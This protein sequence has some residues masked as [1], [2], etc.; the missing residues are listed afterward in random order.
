MP[1]G[2]A[3]LLLLGADLYGGYLS[4]REL[5]LERVDGDLNV[6]H[7]TLTRAV[8]E[9]FTEA[10]RLVRAVRKLDKD[11]EAT[12]TVRERCDALRPQLALFAPEARLRCLAA[13]PPKRSFPVS[14]A[15]EQAYG[16]GE[17][18]RAVIDNGH[19][20]S[21]AAGLIEWDAPDAPIA[22]E[23]EL[24]LAEATAPLRESLGIELVRLDSRGSREDKA[25]HWRESGWKTLG[26]RTRERLR[27]ALAVAETREENILDFTVGKTGYRALLSPIG[28]HFEHGESS[29][30]FLRDTSAELSIVRS[31]TMAW[32]LWLGLIAVGMYG[33]LSLVVSGAER[34]TLA[35]QAAAAKEA[36]DR[37][38]V[39]QRGHDFLGTLL[40]TIPSA[41]FLKDHE[42]RFRLFNAAFANNVCGQ[43]PSEIEGRTLAQLELDV[44]IED[45]RKIEVSDRELVEQGG[46]KTYEHT[47]RRNDGSEQHYLINKVVYQD[48]SGQE[49]GI[50]GV[51]IDITARRRMEQELREAKQAAESATRAKSAFLAN[52]SHE[53]RTPMNGIIA[54]GD[55]LAQT[56]LEG[57]AR[58]YAHTIQTCGQSLLTLISDILDF[59]K[60]EAGRLEFDTVVF[61]PR[62]IVQQICDMLSGAALKKDI[63]LS[64][65][66]R[67]D[68]PERVV[69]DP[70]RIRQV[71][72]NLAGNGLKFTEEGGVNLEVSVEEQDHAEVKLRF[73]IQD[74]GIGIEPS[75]LSALYE[76]FV[77]A[78]TSL[79]R[80]FGGTGL[81]LAIS[82]A[83][84]A[85]MGGELG[86]ESRPGRGS[87][88]WFTARV[89]VAHE[90]TLPETE[91]HS[92]SDSEGAST[93]TINP[94][95]APARIL[96]AEDNPVN[97]RVAE[98]ILEKLGHE[99]TI[100]E[101]GALAVEAV[102]ESRFDLVLMDCQMPEMDGYAA[103]RAIRAL[104]AGLTQHTPIVALTAHAMAHDRDVCLAAG[105]DDYVAKPVRPDEL[106]ARLAKW[107]SA[108]AV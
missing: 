57:E 34:R 91:E 62:V 106:A 63:A 33:A 42:G 11:R 36:A 35:A 90:T 94:F 73:R 14:A 104:E 60:M 83:L 2:I 9:S 5:A 87:T 107:L 13:P 99:V 80:R 19:G 48:R 40:D 88:F 15:L 75:R 77:Q 52:V 7:A 50:V 41:V 67:D 92:T 78:D 74:T 55:L 26:A 84:V 101:N 20:L 37:E 18:G 72:L 58:E 59:S 86:A 21:V 23:V 4:E 100:V 45:L 93:A 65:A 51:M 56:P 22:L 46:L 68:V 97:Q 16:S 24:S 39:E 17:L 79:T 98:R 43:A 3:M 81:G 69:G 28:A 1:A 32:A 85:G 31:K 25:L 49:S 29:L 6:A 76:P 103:T 30:V 54:F 105:M 44:P 27:E 8:R 10:E 96:V 66:V 64:C 102:R 108:E 53:I 95:A 89:P 38:S 82:R 47:I 71:L 12:A 61:E 70:G